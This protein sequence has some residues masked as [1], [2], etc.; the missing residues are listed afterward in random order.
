MR[1]ACVY[2]NKQELGG[3]FEFWGC[4]VVASCTRKVEGSLRK[5]CEQL[6]IKN[7]SFSCYRCMSSMKFFF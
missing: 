2:E 1:G 5:V 7:R 4:L 3:K 6:L